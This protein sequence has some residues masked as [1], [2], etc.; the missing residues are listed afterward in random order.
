MKRLEKLMIGTLLSQERQNSTV[1][2]YQ[3]DN[4]SSK[5]RAA[6]SFK[7]LTPFLADKRCSERAILFDLV[8]DEQKHNSALGRLERL[9]RTVLMSIKVKTYHL[10]KGLETHI[11]KLSPSIC[12]RRVS[13]EAVFK[14]T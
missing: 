14:R 13:A 11:S 8:I 7:T 3:C 1:E 12:L 9:Q 5:N 4:N 10:L 6:P 2:K